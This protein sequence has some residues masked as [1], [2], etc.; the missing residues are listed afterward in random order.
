VDA[1]ALAEIGGPAL[2]VGGELPALRDAGAIPPFAR[3]KPT[4][5]SQTG[6]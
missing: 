4:S 3:S 2:T 1:L 5:E 6:A